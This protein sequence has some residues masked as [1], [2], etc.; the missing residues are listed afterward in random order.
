MRL[1]AA[2]L[3]CLLLVGGCGE[4]V[5]FPPGDLFIGLAPEAPR[6][7]PGAGIPLTVTR[8]WRTDHEPAPWDDAVLAPL[9]LR[10]ERIATTTLGGRVMEQRH[11]RAYAFA[12]KDV[13]VPEIVFA[14][15]RDGVLSV[16]R[17]K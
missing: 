15:H 1:A 4:P 13:V 17:S 9:T 12:L 7:R 5:A 16:A 14:A 10:D 2:L 11:Y 3:G 8:V 6:V